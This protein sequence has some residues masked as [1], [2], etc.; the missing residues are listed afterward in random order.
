MKIT[1]YQLKEAIKLKSLELSTII[2]QFDESLHFFEGSIKPSP[3]EIAE[4]AQKLEDTIVLLQVAQDYY[5]VR[6]KFDDS[7]TLAGAIKAVGGYGRRAKLFREAATGAKKERWDRGTPATRRAG[8]VTAVPTITKQEALEEAIKY[9]RRAT[10]LRT[11]IAVTNSTVLDVSILDE[12]D[13][14]EL[15]S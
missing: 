12:A 7:K 9:E 6:V 2:S 14:K 8:E 11:Q 3:I 1:G 15:F 5:N 4:K 13:P 10:H